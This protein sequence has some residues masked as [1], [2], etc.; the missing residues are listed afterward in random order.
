MP[1]ILGV[2]ILDAELAFVDGEQGR[3]PG[4][5]RARECNN[6]G[7]GMLDLGIGKEWKGKMLHIG[8]SLSREED[9]NV[10]LIF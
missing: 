2:V 9:G 6:N 5:Y 4:S 10:L 3:Q 7:A 1:R 8:Q